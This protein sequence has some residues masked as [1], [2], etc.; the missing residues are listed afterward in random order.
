VK[1]S[2]CDGAKFITV[3]SHRTGRLGSPTALMQ[4]RT[5]PHCWGSGVSHA[6]AEPRP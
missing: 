5:C 6:G 3:A 1:C 4:M 2:T